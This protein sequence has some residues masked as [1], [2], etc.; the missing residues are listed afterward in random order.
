MLLNFTA[1]C[2][3]LVLI[4]AQAGPMPKQISECQTKRR[5]AK[6]KT[7]TLT[8]SS[9]YKLQEAVCPHGNV[10]MRKSEENYVIA[11]QINGIHY[12]LEYGEGELGKMLTCSVLAS[13][14]ISKKQLMRKMVQLVS[15]PTNS[16]L[17]A[18][19]PFQWWKYELWT[20]EFLGSNP[21]STITS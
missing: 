17:K 4:S 14:T 16:F 21:G 7:G 18:R 8:S 11:E 5:T 3:A 15:S 2:S 6:V 10:K 13:T 20:V 19:I 9:W 1:A 12:K